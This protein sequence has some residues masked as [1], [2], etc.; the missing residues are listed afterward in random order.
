M[1]VQTIINALQGKLS[2]HVNSKLA[3]AEFKIKFISLGLVPC[4]SYDKIMI[5][6]CDL[7]G[8]RK[9]KKKCL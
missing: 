4:E 9:H 1:G 5:R 3:S 8:V 2:P 6:S 7:Y